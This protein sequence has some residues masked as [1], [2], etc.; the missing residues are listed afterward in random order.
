MHYKDIL[1][2][3]KKIHYRD[4]GSGRTLVLLHGF[5]GSLESWNTYLLLYMREM[6]VILIDLPGHGKSDVFDDVHTMEFMAST[7]KAV[8]DHLE[9]K[10]CVMIGHSMGGYVTLAFAER[11]SHMLRGFGLLHSHAL[12]DNETGKEN[13]YRACRLVEESR[14]KYIVSFIPEL[15]AEKRRIHL[16]Q[17]IKELQE[18]SLETSNEGIIAAQKGMALRP[19]RTRVLQNATVP[20]LFV[21]GGED[22]RISI[23][24]G[25]SQAMLAQHSEITIL[26]NV[27]HMSPVEE[28]MIIKERIRGFVGQCFLNYYSGKE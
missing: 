1:I 4:E 19:S 20:V 17:E 3:G 26:S 8:L 22:S 6:R 21:F 28:P 12:P 11:Y 7:V 14:A 10:E 18:L 2:D 15:F 16:Q 24:L 9:V 25:V 23:E 5:M 27:G 13:R